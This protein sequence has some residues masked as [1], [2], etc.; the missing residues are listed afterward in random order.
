MVEAMAETLVVA[1]L[2]VHTQVLIGAIRVDR[3]PSEGCQRSRQMP[4]I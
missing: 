4:A 1:S 3:R 2:G